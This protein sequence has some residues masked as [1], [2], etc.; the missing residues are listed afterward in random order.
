MAET[1]KKSATSGKKA[2]APAEARKSSSS[3]TPATQTS[4][5]KTTATAAARKVTAKSETSKPAT[6]KVSTKP[7]ASKSKSVKA[8]KPAVAEKFP[9]KQKN[10]ISPE[11]RFQMISTA[12]YFLAEQRGFAAGYEMHDWIIAE[13]QIDSQL[14]ATA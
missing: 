2:T 7:A 13:A 4:K 1:L 10:K 11:Q 9:A 12:A 5:S 3:K 6:T 8:S 14:S